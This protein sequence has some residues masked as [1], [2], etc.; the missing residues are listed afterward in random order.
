MKNQMKN[1]PVVVGPKVLLVG[2][3]DR[4]GRLVDLPVN[5]ADLPVNQADHLE[6]AEDGE[7]RKAWIEPGKAWIEPG[8]A[9]IEPR[10]AQ[11]QRKS[12]HS[13]QKRER[14]KG[15]REWVTK[16]SRRIPSPLSLYSGPAEKKRC[17]KP[18]SENP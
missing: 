15:K 5:Q 4:L 3:A 2:R 9:W 1:H 18:V 13:E 8:K 14:G 7:P 17:R 11:R 6:G 12:E 10:K 16:R